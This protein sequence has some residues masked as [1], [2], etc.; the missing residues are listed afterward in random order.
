[1]PIVPAAFANTSGDIVLR[2]R[3]LRLPLTGSAQASV[4]AIRFAAANHLCIDLDYRKLDGSVTHPC[5][6]LASAVR[7]HPSI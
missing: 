3:V 5:C 7:E 6:D 1:M 4:E 2:E